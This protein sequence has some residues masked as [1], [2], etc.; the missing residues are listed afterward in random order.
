VTEDAALR[1][2]AVRALDPRDVPAVAGIHVTAFAERAPD[3]LARAT[4]S[5]AE[6]L[7][8]PWAHVRVACREGVVI[9]A[10]VAWVVADE[11]H[12]LDVATDPG[13]RRQGVGR[14]LVR[15]LVELARAHHAGHMY[16]EVRRSNVA[17]IALYRDAGFAAV[18]FR[19]RYYADDEDAVEMALA[20]DAT[21]LDVARRDDEV[22]V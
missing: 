14:A 12:V 6:E 10:A 17:A 19:V 4:S 22:V 21:T 9:G 1:D 5:L 2:I 16:L 8:R 3:A 20:F 13:H 11:V 7:A 15:D 18:G